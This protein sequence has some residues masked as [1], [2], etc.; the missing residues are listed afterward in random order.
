MIFDYSNDETLDI[1]L[2]GQ[3]IVSTNHGDDGWAGM[4][5]IRTAMRKVAF[6]L[7]V[8]VETRGEVNV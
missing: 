4:K 2:N 7:D 1:Y 6:V 8:A 5:R 3:L